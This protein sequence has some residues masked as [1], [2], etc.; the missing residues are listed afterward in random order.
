[1]AKKARFED[2]FDAVKLGDE[3][4]EDAGVVILPEIDQ[5]VPDADQ[6]RRGLVPDD[7]REML[8]SGEMSPKKV[9]LQTWERC[10]DREVHK[11]LKSGSVT[12][13][14]ALSL[15][16]TAGPRDLALQLSLEG[17]VALADSIADHGLVQPVN[18]YR[19][20]DGRYRITVGERRWW[21]HVHLWYVMGVEKARRIRAIELPPPE[22]DLER[23]AQQYAENVH[24][25]DLSDIAK[26][27]A[28]AGVRGLVELEAAAKHGTSGSMPTSVEL[29][30][31]AGRRVAEITG[32]GVSGRTVRHYLALL[33]MPTEARRLAEAARLSERSLRD[34]ATLKDPAA[35]VRLV[36][37][38]A[39][40]AITATDA[41][42]RAR[43]IK[44]ARRGSKAGQRGDEDQ[45]KKA[46]RR[47]R[48]SVEFA[49]DDPPKARV[50]A[51]E[52]A[53]LP[54]G[55]RTEVVDLAAAYA[56]YLVGVLEALEKELPKAVH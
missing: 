48:S 20:T 7:L 25:K 21:A 10:L 6:P 11:A 15:Q 50:L 56:E 18:V 32:R 9:I 45:L 23:V 12:P 16:R 51:R 8:L 35:Q 42:E 39:K 28:I 27:R 19:T 34:V 13:S 31:M 49:A 54:E 52:I 46:L 36:T 40:E 53:S 30:E 2:F 29:D 1:V 26:A 5:L 33:S 41:S 24:R 4:A 38:L 14:S 17:L 3:E 44:A 47:F 22:D 37:Q 55:K 43:A